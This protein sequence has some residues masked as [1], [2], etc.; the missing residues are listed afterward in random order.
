MPVQLE[1]LLSD[2]LPF[3]CVVV[4]RRWNSAARARTVAL[5]FRSFCRPRFAVGALEPLLMTDLSANRIG[6]ANSA[7]PVP[8][9]NR[10]L[11]PFF[12]R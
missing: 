9:E 7:V 12:W 11:D 2:E 3:Q 1:K 4:Q 8:C 5:H 10:S 6:P